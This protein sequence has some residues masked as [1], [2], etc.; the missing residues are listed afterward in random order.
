MVL[1]SFILHLGQL[2]LGAGITGSRALWHQ[3]YCVIFKEMIKNPSKLDLSKHCNAQLINVSC[4]YVDIDA[5]L[6]NQSNN[7]QTLVFI[8]KITVSF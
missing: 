6:A 5:G 2:V 4:M 8:T 7:F 3:S 1:S